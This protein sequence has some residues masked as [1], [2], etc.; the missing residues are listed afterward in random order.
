M[1]LLLSIALWVDDRLELLMLTLSGWV[2]LPP[3]PP[4]SPALLAPIGGWWVEPC[5]GLG[6]VVVGLVGESMWK[7]KPVLGSAFSDQVSSSI[8]QNIHVGIQNFKHYISKEN[9][10]FVQNILSHRVPEEQFNGFPAYMFMFMKD[11]PSELS[12]IYVSTNSSS[13]VRCCSRSDRVREQRG[14]LRSFSKSLECGPSVLQGCR[15][16]AHIW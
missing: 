5:C 16:L 14:E 4:T 9:I 1:W 13:L 3:P 6:V 11:D 2:E 8:L 15:I 10:T 7:T 12:W